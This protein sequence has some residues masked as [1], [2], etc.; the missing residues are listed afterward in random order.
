V[1]SGTVAPAPTAAQQAPAAEPYKGLA[2]YLESDSDLFFGRDRE[3]EIIC[4][5]LMAARLTLLY[6][7]SGV[8]KSSVLLAGAVHRLREEAR[9]NPEE[10]GRPVRIGNDVNVAVEAERRFGAGGSR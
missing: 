10:L 4:A 1:T 5:N 9:R 7:E 3:I 8:G 2:P 6:G